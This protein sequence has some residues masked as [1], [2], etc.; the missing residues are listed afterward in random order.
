MAKKCP[1]ILLNVAPRGC[2]S[3][4]AET[5]ELKPPSM[6]ISCYFR[7]LI[8][9]KLVPVFRV[10]FQYIKTESIKCRIIILKEK[11]GCLKNYSFIKDINA[12]ERQCL[13]SP[14]PVVCWKI[15]LPHSCFDLL[16]NYFLRHD[17]TCEKPAGLTSCQI[18]TGIKF[19]VFCGEGALVPPKETLHSSRPNA[20]EG[21]NVPGKNRESNDNAA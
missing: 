11:R 2:S 19:Q 8:L 15:N 12:F 18:E 10:L 13:H 14:E 7:D 1:Q 20:T 4:P 9:L 21:S 16:A 17:L 3:Q 5:Q 6:I